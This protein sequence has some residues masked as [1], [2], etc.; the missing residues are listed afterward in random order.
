M[1]AVELLATLTDVHSFHLDVFKVSLVIFSQPAA[2]IGSE[3]FIYDSFCLK[4]F[5]IY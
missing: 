1:K 4:V 2:F 5:D 3:L